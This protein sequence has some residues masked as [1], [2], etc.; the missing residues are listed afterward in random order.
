MVLQMNNRIICKHVFRILQKHRVLIQMFS[1]YAWKDVLRIPY[2]LIKKT[3]KFFIS[4]GIFFLLK[5]LLGR[6]YGIKANSNIGSFEKMYSPVKL[7]RGFQMSNPRLEKMYW[8]FTLLYI[9]VQSLLL[10]VPFECRVKSKFNILTYIIMYNST[11]KKCIMS[12][13]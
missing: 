11:V 2:S 4:L 5:Y 13:L 12:N 3:N 7:H 8:K 6:N 10:K 1:P 9:S